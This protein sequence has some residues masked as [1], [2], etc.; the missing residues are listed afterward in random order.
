MR[1]RALIVHRTG[2][3]LRIRIPEKRKD[4][5]FFL[6]VYNHLRHIPVVDEVVINPATASVLLLFSDT[7]GDAVSDVLAQ[8]EMFSL[9]DSDKA[10]KPLRDQGSL[11]GSGVNRLFPSRS[12]SA[13]EFR[14]ILFLIMTG[15]AIHQA[16]RGQILIPAL[17]VLWYAVDL[18]SGFK[19]TKPP[20]EQG[21]RDR[22]L[23]PLPP[24]RESP[25][26]PA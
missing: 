5:S 14:A 22:S 3:R 24:I 9:G 19:Q 23:S 12:S 11:S 2:G 7:A 8:H 1:P 18:V 20:S 6:N 15:L 4:L 26:E 21:P 25:P 13:N 10:T 17:S 16:L